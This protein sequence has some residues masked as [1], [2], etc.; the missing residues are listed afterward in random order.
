MIR[1]REYN[2]IDLVAPTNKT[3]ETKL[4][5]VLSVLERRMKDLKSNLTGGFFSHPNLGYWVN[6][7]NNLK[8][9]TSQRNKVKERRVKN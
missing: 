7:Y 9:I 6:L 4:V 5:M 2:D 3:F 8:V 1:E